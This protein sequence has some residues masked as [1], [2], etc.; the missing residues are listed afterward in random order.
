[1]RRL[2]IVAA[3][4]AL[5]LSAGVSTA[6]QQTGNIV[7]RVADNSG[8]VL[9]GV[10]VTI[11]GPALLQSRVLS[12]SETGS[13]RAPDLPIGTY[14][15]KFELAGFRTVVYS[16]IRV[17]IGFNAEVDAKLDVSAVEETITVSGESP[18]VDTKATSATTTFDNESLQTIPSARDPWVIL[19]RTPGITMDRTNV[20]GSQSGQQ[21]YYTSRGANNTNNQWA[22]D[23]VNIT[24]MS[25]TGASPIYYDF[26][27]L[28]EMQVTTGGADASQQTGGVG[29]NL[30]TRS[31]TD[32][33]RGSARYYLTDDAVEADN[34]TDELRAQ[35]AT[36]GNPI[37]NIRD[38]GFEVGG[39]IM[40]GKLWYW[41]SV[42]VQNIKVGVLGFYKNTPT[43]RPTPPTDTEGL[44]AC[45]ETDLTE[46]NNY[47]WKINWSPVTNNKF[48]FQNTWAEKVRNARDAS[49][50]R[51][52]ETTYRQKAVS[53][54]FGTYGWDVG[55]SPL[56]KAS[57]QHVISDRWLVEVQWAHLGNNFVLDFHEDDLADV[58]PTFEISSGLWGRSYLRN[59]PFIRPTHS[60]DLTT[61]Y[62]LPS[63][64]GGDHAF[65]A[66]FR[67]RAAD[68]HSEIHRGGNT[69]AR[70][71]NGAVSEA[72]LYR[73]SV[74][75]YSLSTLAFYVQDTYTVNRFT[76]N[77]G[78]R[79]DQQSNEALGSSVPAH[80]FAP[81]WLPA[82]TFDG[83]DGIT[84][85]DWSPRLGVNYDVAGNGHTIARASFAVYYGQMAP[86][87]GVG[88]L[89]PVTEASIRFPWTDTNGDRFVQANELDYSRILSFGGNYNP[90]RPDFLGTSGSVDSDV[91]NDR[92]REFI[93]GIDHEIAAG[94]AV[95]ASYIWR[96]YDQFAWNDT[97]NWTSA[98]YRSVTYTP[99]A[100][101]C[102]GESPRCETITYWEP[103][104]PIPAPYIYT[105]QPD[106]WRNYN[107][108]ELSARK[109][110][111]NRWGANAS[112]A[113]NDAVDEWGSPDAYEDPTN[114]DTLDGAQ[115]A[116]EQTGSGRTNIYPNSK[117]LVKVSGNYLF[118]WDINVSGFYNHRQGYPFP[119]SINSPSRPNRGGIAEVWLDPR[120]DVRYTDLFTIDFR[121]DKTFNLGMMKV[122][123]AMDVF[124]LSNVNTVMSRRRLQNDP[125]T[126]NYVRE[127][128]A[129]RIIRFGVRVTW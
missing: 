13:Y 31:G 36:S 119:Q 101:A 60:V 58:Q 6:Q 70:F 124:N 106:R 41:G 96:K 9:P 18:I 49:D 128:V 87:Q 40:K 95:G 39:P 115:Y 72:D 34:V 66:G 77:L 94:F 121:V 12:T 111:S 114:I 59:G 120:G 125:R 4:L 2:T 105:N 81:Q 127:I 11:S 55:P 108:F 102:G 50:L 14:T 46:L 89:N 69:V 68:Q 47:N 7:G 83:A 54:D 56:W 79:W 84:F 1:M 44:R 28:E 33:F 116:E 85:N 82:V 51:P 86:G 113:Y 61:N 91:E 64:M 35:G 22:V 75:D 10:T 16:D 92:T 20:G 117:W 21:S 53:S 123:P 78:L 17:T 27:M 129:P 43:C 100:S 3:V 19:E 45:L 26:D 74:T 52:I 24:D 126:A 76:F 30:V 5:V 42:G 104:S 29:I 107:G 63:V 90:D 97:L 23:G 93:V 62:F 71:R 112:F 48:A 80:P 67:W 99:P 15:V 25:A 32:R 118:P 88:A 73:D 109:R 122:I 110:F 8:A 38:Y 103:T 65:K 37:Q 98:N 57:D